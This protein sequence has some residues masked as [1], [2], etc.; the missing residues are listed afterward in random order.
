M[1]NERP[2][3]KK[4]GR[5]VPIPTNNLLVFFLDNQPVAR[6][7]SLRML[8]N[9]MNIEHVMYG[10]VE[11]KPFDLISNLRTSFR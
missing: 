8:N 7:L 1:T 11:T 10:I 3:I 2:K 6:S 5:M 9:N 4:A